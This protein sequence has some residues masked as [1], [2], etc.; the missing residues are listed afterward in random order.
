M[1]SDEKNVEFQQVSDSF[2]YIVSLS[3]S[4]NVF[5]YPSISFNP[6]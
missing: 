5:Q 4:F 3:I 1:R 2:R 6:Q